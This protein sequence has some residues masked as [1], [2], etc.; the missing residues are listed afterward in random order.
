MDKF[1]EQ[2]LRTKKS[3]TY[4]LFVVAMNFSI[5]MAILTLVGSLMILDL[6]MLIFTVIFG[7]GFFLLRNLKDKQYKEYEYIFTNGNLQIDIIFNK[8]KRK[9]LYD[10]EMKNLDSFGKSSDIKINNGVK[11]ISCIP[12]DNVDEKYVLLISKNGKQAI[13]IAPNE[14]LLKLLNVYK[15]RI[16]KI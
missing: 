2:L 11:K 8:K 6:K 13:Y 7:V 15:S 10:L 12:W 3:P 16:S 9:S 14:E 5:I 1:H 4:K